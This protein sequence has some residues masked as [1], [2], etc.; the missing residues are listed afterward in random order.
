M[1]RLILLTAVFVTSSL[2]SFADG[3]F[4]FVRICPPAEGGRAAEVYFSELAAAGDPRFI[5]KVAAAKFWIQTTPGEFRPLEML[6]LSDR[7]RAHVPIGGSLMVAGQLDYGV[8]AREG[9]T[10]FLLRHYSKAVAGPGD[11]VNR[12]G[13][14]GTTLEVVATF[15]ADRILVTSLLNGKPLP[16]ATFS[17]VDAN[18]A[19]EELKADADGRAAFTPDAPGVYSIYT[20][21]DDHTPGTHNGAPYKEIR[22]FATLSFSW[23]LVPTGADPQAVKLFEDAIAARAV[24]KDFPGFTAQIDGTVEDRPFEGRLSVAADGSV[25]LELAEDVV[26][27]WV[28]DQ[29]ESITMHRAAS[30]SPSADHP[31]PVLRFA[32][33]HEDHPLGRL[34]AFEGGHFATSYRVKGRQI[35]SVNRFVDGKNMTITVL[36]NEKNADGLFLPRSYAVQYWDEASGKLERTE[37]VEDRWTRIGSWDLPSRH[38]VT[39]AS[40]G[41]FSVRGFRVSDHQLIGE[42]SR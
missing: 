19:G 25:K 23:P 5:A 4:L 17:T 12:F 8:L 3:H 30:Q 14:K 39:A 1:P 9:Q 15:E 22:Q 2:A 13:P 7:L 20:R 31:K 24:W 16:G 36:D 38:T 29:M 11:E 21:H 41:G 33:D 18:L 28:Q 10:P 40:D 42:H 37:T 6:K 35:S 32:D 26:Q 34:L 27:D